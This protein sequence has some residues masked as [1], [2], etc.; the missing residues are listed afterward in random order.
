M[1]TLADEILALLP[2][3]VQ[4]YSKGL[5]AKDVAAHL[6]CTE[7]NAHTAFDGIRDERRAQ[8]VRH[9]ERGGLRRI[10]P[11]G[12]DFGLPGYKAKACWKCEALYSS[13]NQFYCS[14]KC[15][16]SHRWTR[17]GYKE[18]VGAAISEA[19]HSPEQQARTAAHNK[20]R[21][22]KPGE[23]EKMAEQNRREWSDP[24]KRA[25]RSASIQAVHG[26]PE[27]RKFYS[28]LRKA[29]WSDPEYYRMMQ[30]KMIAAKN[31]PEF[32]AKFSEGLK[33]RWQDPEMRP[34]FMAAVKRNS[35]L[36]AERA[37]KQWADP[38]K[39][40]ALLAKQREAAAKARRTK[41]SGPPS[42]LAQ[43][44]LDA[45]LDAEPSPMTRGDLE[46]ATGQSQAQTSSSIR[47]LERHGLIAREP[48]SVERARESGSGGQPKYAWAVIRQKQAKRA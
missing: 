16:A 40:P 9:K 41:L 5:T 48:C 2:D 47:V 35:A 13:Q 42:Q 24:V 32:R 22:S 27:S 26:T 33:N 17:P 1:I 12:H 3:L 11:L 14:K 23:R 39:R 21:W 28:D 15:S 36:A 6:S 20:K 43:A 45:L 18:R 31:T 46:R 7:A 34:K 4:P 8:I 44:V 29:N 25:K 19:H 10:V 37:R 30:A 38:E